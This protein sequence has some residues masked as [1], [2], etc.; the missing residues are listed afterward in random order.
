DHFEFDEG[1]GWL[2]FHYWVRMKFVE[3][4]PEC[5][6]PAT[7]PENCVNHETDKYA[8]CVRDTEFFDEELEVIY[9]GGRHYSGGCENFTQGIS[10]GWK[11]IYD[12]DLPGQV[13]IVGTKAAA[14]ALGPQVFE[15]EINPERV[16]FEADYSNN[17]STIAVEMPVSAETLCDD[18]GRVLDCTVSPSQYDLIQRRQCPV[19]FGFMGL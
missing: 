11:D 17:L 8:F 3:P 10:P 15:V 7:R 6:D 2:R 19:Y 12:K 16:L 4:R 18:P 5:T 1:R 13:L 9:D 14:N